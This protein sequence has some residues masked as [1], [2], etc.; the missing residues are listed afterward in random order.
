MQLSG[1]SGTSAAFP[2]SCCYESRVRPIGSAYRVGALCLRS[3]GPSVTFVAQSRQRCDHVAPGG[4][5][6]TSQQGNYGLH[7]V[8]GPPAYCRPRRFGSPLPARPSLC[9]G[10]D[11]IGP[12]RCASPIIPLDAL[13]GTSS[14]WP[15]PSHRPVVT[16]N[17]VKRALCELRVYRFFGSSGLTYCSQAVVVV[18]GAL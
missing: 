11:G 1:R 7:H 14:R 8:P 9:P 4:R 12:A 17:F 15:G 13:A 6:Y 3:S 16:T 10:P 5:E 18:S 2:K